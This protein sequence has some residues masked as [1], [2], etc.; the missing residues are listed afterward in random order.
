MEINVQTTP[1]Y[2]PVD[3]AHVL[4]ATISLFKGCRDVEVHLFRAKWSPQEVQAYNWDRLVTPPAEADDKR[5]VHNTRTFVL[6]AFTEKERDQL[7]SY[8]Q[9]HYEDRISRLEGHTLEFPL[10]AGITPLSSVEAT[11]EMGLILFE[12]IPHYSL[13]FT[14]HGFYDLSRH[15]PAG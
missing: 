3:R 8:F 1:E 12:K 5:A 13:P 7:V 4:R 14:V 6:E 9:D 10:P 15:T 2:L 11:G